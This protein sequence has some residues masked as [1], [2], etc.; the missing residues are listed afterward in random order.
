M[1][2]KKRIAN[3]TFK[4]CLLLI[5]YTIFLILGVINWSTV[6]KA[7]LKVISVFMPFI[8]GLIFAY[9]FNLPMKFFESKLK[10]TK[11]KRKRALSGI[12]SITLVLAILIGIFSVIIPLVIENII[13]FATN[14]DAYLANTKNII[15]QIFEFLNL[16]PDMFDQ[17]IK[18][19]VTFQEDV[20]NFLEQQ[21][22]IIFNYLGNFTS[23]VFNTFSGIVIAIY[24]VVS[25]NKLISQFK[26]VLKAFVPQA[27]YDYFIY[28]GNITNKVFANFISGQLIEAIILGLMCM[29][30]CFILDIPYAPLLGIIIGFTNVIPI[31]GPIFGTI[32]CAL[33]IFIIDPIKSVIFVIFILILQQFE[34]NIIYPKVVGSSLGLSSIWVLLGVFVGGGLF[35]I[36]GILIGIPCTAIIYTLV[37]AEVA[38]RLRVETVEIEEGGCQA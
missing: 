22:P 21:I 25:K 6:I 30:G 38:K 27:S 17:L 7:V 9:I 28:V 14:S 37:E 18:Y 24:L 35:G 33:L 11:I 1:I 32:P 34:S 19:A 4:D 16:P 12:L 5:T 31:F 36:L 29:V 8:V 2:H 26:T 3:L 23:G 13:Q 10:N 15:E 20:F